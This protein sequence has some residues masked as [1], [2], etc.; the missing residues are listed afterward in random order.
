MKKNKTEKNTLFVFFYTKTNVF[1]L[2]FSFKNIL[3]YSHKSFM[4]G[5]QGGD[6]FVS[7][8]SIL[9]QCFP[10][11]KAEKMTWLFPVEIFGNPHLSSKLHSL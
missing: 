3:M 6:G 5:R 8:S 4:H 11:K 10:S 9:T 1:C 7:T 2:K